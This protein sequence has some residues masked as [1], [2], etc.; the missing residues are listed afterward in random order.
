[1]TAAL[2]QDHQYPSSIIEEWSGLPKM[3][4]VSGMA[5]KRASSVDQA[6]RGSLFHRTHSDL[7]VALFFLRNFPNM[8]E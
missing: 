3:Y 8:A 6:A 4:T 7:P 1:M 5:L 2:G